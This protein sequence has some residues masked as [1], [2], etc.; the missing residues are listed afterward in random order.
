MLMVKQVKKEL[1]SLDFQN[2]MEKKTTSKP[3]KYFLN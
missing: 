2:V 3:R 1:A